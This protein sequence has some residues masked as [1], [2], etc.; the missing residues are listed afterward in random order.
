MVKFYVILKILCL[1][2]LFFL[3]VDVPVSGEQDNVED[4]EELFAKVFGK[5]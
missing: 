1:S 3:I 4:L 5:S 2:A